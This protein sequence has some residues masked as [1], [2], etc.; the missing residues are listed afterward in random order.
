MQAFE[1]ESCLQLGLHG[2]QTEEWPAAHASNTL[3][4]WD[5]AFGIH[6]HILPSFRTYSV[7]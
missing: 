2:W 1:I 5:A 4:H 3:A 6:L 7:P